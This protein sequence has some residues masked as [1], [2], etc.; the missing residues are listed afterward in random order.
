LRDVLRN[1]VGVYENLKVEWVHGATP[2]A[3]LYDADK[4]LV[5]EVVLGDKDLKEVLQLL[6]EH[7]FEPTRKSVNLGEPLRSVSFGGHYY[8]VF[9]GPILFQDAVNWTATR[10]HDNELGYLLTIS[11]E[12]ENNFISKTLSELGVQTA[13]LGAQDETEGVWKWIGGP[14][15]DTIFWE[16]SAAVPAGHSPYGVFVNWKSGEPNNV[17]EE[18][19]AV[20]MANG[21][22]NDAKCS[23]DIYSVVVEFGSQPLQLSE[24]EKQQYVPKQEMVQANKEEAHPDL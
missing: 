3:F 20:V 7:G 1:Q 15:K 18:D 14:E 21:H 22:W 16:V 2:T 17:E 10:K 4:N 19:C 8:E 9:L 5:A 11:S 6:K 23:T 12:Q 24:A 13:W